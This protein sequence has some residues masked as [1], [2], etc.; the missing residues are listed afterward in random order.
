MSTDLPRIILFYPRETSIYIITGLSGN[1]YRIKATNG[2]IDKG[3]SDLTMKDLSL[4]DQDIIQK[5][6]SLK[7]EPIYNKETE[8]YMA[9]LLNKISGF[10]APITIKQ[11]GFLLSHENCLPKVLN[12]IYLK[13]GTTKLE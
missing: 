1:Y 11:Y 3:G 4:K 2:I 8:E 5:I 9:F 6:I 10:Y 13:Y 12:S 7:I